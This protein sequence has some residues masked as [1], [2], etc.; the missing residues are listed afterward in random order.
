MAVRYPLVL[1]NDNTIQEVPPGDTIFLFP[2][3][4]PVTLRSGE[5]LNLPVTDGSF[6]TLTRRDGTTV[7]ILVQT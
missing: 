7:N 2:T 1:K 5:L 3:S 4:L 6:I